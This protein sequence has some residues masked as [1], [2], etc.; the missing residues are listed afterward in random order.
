V[1]D[2]RLRPRRTSTTYAVRRPLVEW[3]RQRADAVSR[4]NES[5]RTLDVG[6]GARPYETLFTHA[7]STYVG[8]DVPENPLADVHG[9][10]SD[11]P[12][13]DASFDLVLCTQVLEH[14]PDPAGA[15]RELRRVLRPGGRAL[16]STHGVAVFHPNPEDLWR[17]THTGL[18]QLFRDN[19]DWSSVE[20]SSGAGSAATV[21]MLIAHFT[22]LLFKRAGARVLARPLVAALNVAGEALDRA[23][24]SLRDQVPG[25]LSANYHVEAVA[26]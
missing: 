14:V 25:S 18:E 2:E 7:R 10:V 8:C 11:L 16:V 3:L 12:V 23:V 17:W 4:E 9:L 6:C 1:P 22:D 15:V 20:V 13:E 24:P 5:L 26:S 19:G 21:T